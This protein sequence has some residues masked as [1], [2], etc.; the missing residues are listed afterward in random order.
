MSPE[1]ARIHEARAEVEAARRLLLS[2]VAPALDRSVPHLERAA[3]HLKALLAA[4]GGPGRGK[5][6]KAGLHG[7]AQAISRVAALLESSAVFYIGWS[8]Q[9][10]AAACGYTRSGE[11]AT[12]GGRPTLS[13][14]G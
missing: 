8:R 4:N 7:L 5:P 1:D 9:V 12:A 14:E 6:E 10:A 13:V 11:P 2:P 3:G